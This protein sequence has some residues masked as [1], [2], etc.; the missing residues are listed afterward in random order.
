MPRGCRTR[1]PPRAGCPGDSPVLLG[2]G[3]ARLAVRLRAGL[4]IRRGRRPAPLPRLCRLASSSAHDRVEAA[5]ARRAGAAL[6]F[7]SPAFA[8]ASHPGAKALGPLRWANIVRKVELPTI[9]LGGVD[10]ATIRKL[11]RNVA[12]GAA[13]IGALAPG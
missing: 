5:R 9:A 12:A 1:Y 11:P 8:T 7:L 3:D 4:H 6:V 2:A 13:A 10:G